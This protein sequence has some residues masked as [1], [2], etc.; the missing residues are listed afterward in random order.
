[1]TIELDIE[2]IRN[3]IIRGK[4]LDG[5]KFD[6][7]RNLEI[8]KDVV[9]SAEGSA[10]VKLG[11]TDIIAGVKME[12]GKPYPDSPADGTMSVSIELL[13]LASPEFEIGPPRE[14][15]IELARVVDRAIRESK[16]I[17]FSKLCI[18]ENE[19]VWMAYIDIDVLNDDGN[20][21]DAC[22]IAAITALLTAKLPKYKNEND[23]Y[24]VEY[25]TKSEDGIPMDGIPVS[26]TFVKIGTEIITDP[27]LPESE[28]LDARLTVGTLEGNKLCSLQKG[29]N[30]GLSVMEIE[31]IIELAVKH[32]D[33]IRSLIKRSIE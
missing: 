9:S 27:G 21:M 25:G 16:A 3:I 28:A 6:E 30:T 33:D 2:L 15:A 5:R 23:K 13:P 18:K 14:N 11:N 31:R 17:D 19:A 29:G 32:G 1:M 7:Y 10:R 24:S 4:R 26:T 22:G 8:E 20:L 12:I